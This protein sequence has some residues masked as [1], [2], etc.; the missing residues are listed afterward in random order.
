MHHIPFE[1]TMRLLLSILLLV[2]LN[3]A[4]A[5][6]GCAPEKM[7]KITFRD[8]TPGHEEDHFVRL[9]KTLYRWSSHFARLEEQPDT[10]NGVHA[11]VVVNNRDTWMINQTVKTGRHI[12]DQAANFDFHAPLVGSHNSPFVDFE[13][14][15][16]LAYMEEREIEPTSIIV[17]DLNLLQYEYSIGSLT[18]RL[19]VYPR[20]GRPWAVAVVERGQLIY[21]LRYVAYETGLEPDMDLFSKPAD[22]KW[23]VAE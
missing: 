8:A 12:V 2:L 19:M 23:E 18:V 15:C 10:K 5:I 16:E 14:G 13:F 7:V 1:V 21:L 17:A 4:A 20:T 9:P 3:P 22:I 11:L 6:A